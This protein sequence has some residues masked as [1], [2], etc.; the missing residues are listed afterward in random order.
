MIRNSTKIFLGN[1]SIGSRI[2]QLFIC[3]YAN[4]ITVAALLGESTFQVG[5]DGE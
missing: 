2:I 1:V 4:M 3:H 5:V